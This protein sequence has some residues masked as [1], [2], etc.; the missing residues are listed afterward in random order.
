MT[1]AVTPDGE[2]HVDR[3]RVTPAV[4]AASLLD[5]G[6]VEL[7]IDGPGDGLEL[8]EAGGRRLKVP[9]KDGHARVLA[10]R[11]QTG[12]DSVWDLAV[13]DGERRLPLALDEPRTWRAGDREVALVAGG[14]GAALSERTPRPVIDAIAWEDDELTVAGTARG[15][16]HVSIA[17]GAVNGFSHD[18]DAEHDGDR[19]RARLTPMRIH[20]LAGTL[21]INEGTWDCASTACP[22][23]SPS[24][25]STRSR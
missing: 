17:R 9:V 20:S 7:A 15:A 21:P 4:R 23:R 5:S 19:F 1:V 13:V 11:L 10:E 2:L 22:R 6:Q 16:T 24:R 3:W 8:R 25:S 14:H 18:F 12:E